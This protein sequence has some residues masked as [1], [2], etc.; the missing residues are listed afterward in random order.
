MPRGAWYLGIGRK[1]SGAEAL[2]ARTGV[3]GS[4]C[5]PLDDEDVLELLEPRHHLRE[6]RDRGDGDRR[7]DE[8]LLVGLD[9]DVRRQDADLVVGDHVADVGEEPER[10]I[11]RSFGLRPLDTIAFLTYEQ[12]IIRRR[13]LSDAKTTFDALSR[14]LGL[15]KERVR[16]LESIALDK[17]RATLAVARRGEELPG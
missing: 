3:R 5:L 8:R 2:A 15:S 4:G 13:Y 12:T 1:S 14:E 16:Q 9:G 11:E 17:L 10:E 7:L 6:L